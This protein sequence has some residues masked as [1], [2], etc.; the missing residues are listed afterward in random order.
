NELKPGS[1]LRAAILYQLFE[2]LSDAREERLAFTR[3][4]LKFYQDIA[5]SDPHPGMLNGVLSLI[6]S[7]TDPAAE[8]E[9]EEQSAVRYFNRAAAFRIFTAYKEEYPTSPELAQ[10]YLDIVRLYAATKE[11]QVASETLKEF[12]SRY[13]DAPQYAEV[14]LKLAD[15]YIAL[16]RYQEER[17]L[18]QRIMDYLGKRRESGRHLV[19]AFGQAQ[20][21]ADGEQQTTS[22]IYSEPTETTPSLAQ[23]PPQSN[24]GIDIPQEGVSE[25]NDSDSRYKD[26]LLTAFS[27]SQSKSA[28]TAGGEEVTYASVLE[29]HVAS[30]AREK[31][32]EA[33]LALYSSE[34]KKY[35]DEQGLYEQ[36]LQWL[37]QTN[38]FEE[39]LKVYK[40]AIAKFPTT[41]WRDRL[42]RWF[43]K[44]ERKQEFETFSRELLDQLSDP[45]TQDYLSK[46]ISSNAS[47]SASNFDAQ[48]Y[49]GLYTLAHERFPHN[50]SF[51]QGLLKFY[52]AHGRT[53]EWRNLMAEYYFESPE[54]RREFL[55]HLASRNELRSFLANARERSRTQGEE[56]Q[57][58][59]L[60]T[61]PYKLFRADA[62]AHLSNYEE[63]ID[64]YRELNRL[65]PNMPEFSERL[66]SFTRSMGQR[67]PKFLEEA[68]S[69]SHALAE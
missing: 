22:S 18:Y 59:S 56:T 17:A 44:R 38:L 67:N 7:D 58:R 40:E 30:L 69:A 9:N 49:L 64:A 19:P 5:T 21:G 12:E 28:K 20:T 57:A 39:Q 24:R 43:L 63:A 50:L 11:P 36:M 46:F 45:E 42:A 34:M 26:Y 8:L 1:P 60:D 53:N 14:A 51:V 65:Y 32:S 4:D 61:L 62:S 55:S 13:E 3:G 54:I 52:S 25:T 23:Y 15:C 16:G 27:N 10:M 29:R 68:A 35:P 48:L 31:Q 6:L 33:I 47:A 37:G 41:V 2:L 66:I